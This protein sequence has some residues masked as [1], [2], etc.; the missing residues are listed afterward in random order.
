MARTFP[1]E[2]YVGLDAALGHLEVA[3]RQTRH[4]LD[5]ISHAGTTDQPME[6]VVMPAATS[7]A[8]MQVPGYPDPGPIPRST[9]RILDLFMHSR[10]RPAA[11]FTLTARP[12]ELSRYRT[13]LVRIR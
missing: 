6:C 9:E 7:Q 3:V 1:G 4:N 8:L 5:A 10:H 11:G 13:Q 12:T 2:G